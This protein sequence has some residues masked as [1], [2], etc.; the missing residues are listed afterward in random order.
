M[1]C[2][3]ISDSAKNKIHQVGRQP[4]KRVLI[5]KVIFFAKELALNLNLKKVK[6]YLMLEN[7]HNNYS[8]KHPNTL[9]LV[10]YWF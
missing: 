10:K 1:L 4:N 9:C 6:S 8:I 2:T 7:K 5:T 3:S